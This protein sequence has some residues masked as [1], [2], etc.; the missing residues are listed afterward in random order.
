MAQRPTRLK[1]RRDFLRVAGKG[2]RA[3][4]PGLVLQALCAASDET[5]IGFTVT[6]KVGNAVVRNRAKRRLREAARLAIPALLAEG[7]MDPGWDL[8]LIGRDATGKRDFATLQGDL[9][10]AL[11]QAGVTR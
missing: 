6:K 9:R 1:R 7:A 5:R 3:A 8:V 10:G 4:R 2:K 11:R